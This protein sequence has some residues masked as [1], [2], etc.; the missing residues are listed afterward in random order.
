MNTSKNIILVGLMGAGKTTIGRQLARQLRRPFV[1]TDQLI[2]SRTGVTIP[3]IFD[4]EGEAGFRR[5][6]REVIAEM[7]LQNNLVLATGGGSVL[8]PVNREH[9][10]R[11]GFVVYLQADVA[12]LFERTK[13]DSHRPLLKTDDPRKQLQRLLAH[14]DPLYREVAHYTVDTGRTSVAKAVSSIAQAFHGDENDQR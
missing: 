2:E 1:D 3:W 13:Q 7:C 8:D 12:V 4:L 6:E 5:R 10:R 9:L 11:H 14:R